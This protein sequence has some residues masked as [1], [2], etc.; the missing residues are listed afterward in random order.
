M[1]GIT[2]LRFCKDIPDQSTQAMTS[3]QTMGRKLRELSDMVY[4]VVTVLY[5]S[6]MLGCMWSFGMYAFF[7]FYELIVTWWLAV[8][9]SSSLSAAY[10][11]SGNQM[12]LISL[13]HVSRRPSP[14]VRCTFGSLISPDSTLQDINVPIF[15]LFYVSYKIFKR[16]NIVRICLITDSGYLHEAFIDHLL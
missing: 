11:H 15:A 14:A 9:L 3:F 13:W 8:R 12:S 2:Y 6:R 7:Y 10:Q 1:I 16:T 5:F 4:M